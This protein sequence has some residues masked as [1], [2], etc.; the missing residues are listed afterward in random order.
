M[1]SHLLFLPGQSLE[2][3]IVVEDGEL[4]GLAAR[5]ETHSELRLTSS[6]GDPDQLPSV[7]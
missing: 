3:S 4:Y 5:V 6:V 7:L 1:F 2:F